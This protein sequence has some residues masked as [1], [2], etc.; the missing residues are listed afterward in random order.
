MKNT[1]YVEII[2][3]G[4]TELQ[5][6]R[7]YQGCTDAP[8][9]QE[10]RLKLQA[11]GRQPEKVYVTSLI[12]TSQTSDI[13]FP[14]VPQIAVPG[15]SEMN[16]GDFEGRSAAEM[17][18]DGDYRR[19]VDGGCEGNCPGGESKQTF[20]DRVCE[21]FTELLDSLEDGPEMCLTIVAHG[22]TQMAVMD[23]FVVPHRDFFKWY[24]PSGRGYRSRAERSDE[25]WRLTDTVITDYTTEVQGS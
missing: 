23:R 25:G 20:S 4:E 17:E 18:Y 10:G 8:L 12:R 14:G 11:A 16:F 7:R 19:W 3:H 2:R 15:L 6:E 5:K 1:L 21:A 13:L 9:S 24:L 22:G